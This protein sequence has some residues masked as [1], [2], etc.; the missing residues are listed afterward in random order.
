VVRAPRVRCVIQYGVKARGATGGCA[1]AHPQRVSILPRVPAARAPRVHRGPMEELPRYRPHLA[2]AGPQLRR[3]GGWRGDRFDLPQD[4]IEPLQAV[5]LPQRRACKDVRVRE[6]AAA[7]ERLRVPAAASANP[8]GGAAA[9]ESPE[10][11]EGHDHHVDPGGCRAD[12]PRESGARVG[13][14]QLSLLRLAGLDRG[15][16][17]PFHAEHAQRVVCVVPRDRYVPGAAEGPARGAAAG[18]KALGERG[19]GRAGG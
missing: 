10:Q 5:P 11:V 6:P 16:P 2:R 9:G 7:A 12:G 4:P 15:V 1:F 18:S 13:H 14:R 3:R 17:G 8:R 19:H